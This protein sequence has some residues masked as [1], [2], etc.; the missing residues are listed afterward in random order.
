MF[1]YVWN[2]DTLK[3]KDED[4][5]VKVILDNANIRNLLHSI[6]N[7]EFFEKVKKCIMESQ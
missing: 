5:Y 7:Y 1:D 3:K 4:E 2:Y 6:K